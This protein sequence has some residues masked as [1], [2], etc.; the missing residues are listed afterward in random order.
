MTRAAALFEKW[1]AVG[2]AGVLTFVAVFTMANRAAGEEVN[3]CAD[4]YELTQSEKMAGHLVNARRNA[5][6]CMGRCPAR[7]ARDCD[8][9]EKNL[10]AEIPAFVVHA[11]D[12]NGLPVAVDVEVDG[13]PASVTELGTIEADPGPHALVL[14][15]SGSRVEVHVDLT[16][17]VRTQV[18][19]V[20]IDEARTTPPP[21]SGA[22]ASTQRDADQ[23]SVSPWRW[24]F[25]GL[26]IASFAAGA[27]IS[28]SG[29]VLD[30]QLQ[31]SCKPTCTQAQA[32]DV[33]N[34]WVI[35]TSLMGG[36]GL[37]LLAALL[38]PAPK[39]TP[40]PAGAAT[41]LVVGPSSINVE[42]TF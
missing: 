15:H 36:G 6:L 32:D 31:N 37:V 30:V 10:A 1:H 20:Q 39:T 40:K 29:E 34:R 11:H 4:T 35:G 26:G 8:A 24:V 38:W 12:S 16:A 2:A 22:F 13:K 42:V 7:L 18:V 41:S 17:G 14:S 23:P 3:G 33:V 9:W 5:R 19:D 27:A 28:I 21:L 25:G